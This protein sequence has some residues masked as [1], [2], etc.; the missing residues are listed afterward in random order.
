MMLK[1][2]RPKDCY[3]LDKEPSR[4]GAKSGKQQKTT[5][6]VLVEFGLKVC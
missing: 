5:L 3:L 1:L 6:D 2:G 4:E